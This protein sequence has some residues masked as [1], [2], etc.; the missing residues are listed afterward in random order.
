MPGETIKVD[1]TELLAIIGKAQTIVHDSRVMYETGLSEYLEKIERSVE[2]VND[3][4][5][6]AAKKEFGEVEA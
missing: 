1:A 2:A 4:I 6:E 5:I 3:I